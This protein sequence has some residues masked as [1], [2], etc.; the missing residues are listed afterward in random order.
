MG[1]VQWLVV[2]LVAQSGVISAAT[3]PSAQEPARHVRVSLSIRDGKTVFRSGEPIRL[4]ASFTADRPGYQVDT[5]IDK[6]A[7]LED[8]I[9]VTPENGAFRW[10]ELLSTP[11]SYGRDYGN[12]SALSARPV[13]MTMPLNYWFRFDEP[14]DYTVRVRTRRVRVA[15]D[16][17]REMPSPWLMTNAVTFKIVMMTEQE[18]EVEARRLSAL[19]DTLPANDLETQTERCEDLAFLTSDAGTREKV[20]RFLH[21]QGRYDGNWI[22]DLRMGLYI[23]RSTSLVI[24]LLEADMRDPTKPVGHIMELIDLRLWM[25][26]PVLVA[27]AQGDMNALRRRK[28]ARIDALRAEYAKEVIASLAQRTGW[29]RRET[30]AS[31]VSLLRNYDGAPLPV[32]PAPLP[33]VVRRV[34]IDE[35]AEL[36]PMTQGYLVQQHWKDIRD[37][38]LLPALERMLTSPDMW[39]RQQPMA[40]ILDIAPER[41]KPIFIAQMLRP[42]PLNHS[43]FLELRDLTLPEMDGPLLEQITRLAASSNSRDRYDLKI[44]TG[45]LARYGSA[46]ILMDVL[47]LY[48]GRASQLDQETRVDLHA[49]LDRWDEAGAAGRLERAL[50]V[51]TDDSMLLYRLA[52]ARYTKA[53]DAV[54]RSRVDSADPWTVEAAASLISQH[55]P[56]DAR[57][58]LE[59]RL[60]RWMNEWSGRTAELEPDPK[61]TTP[62]ARLQI[63]LIRAI[64]NGK[65]WKVSEAD[66]AR[67][68]QSCLT[69]RCRATFAVR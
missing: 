55:G 60:N 9:E 20:R 43:A 39:V 46:A 50:A 17:L 56:A 28:R 62:E 51:E 67:L 38:K 6:N 22:G 33:T 49:Y 42:R 47:R 24:A 44:K 35:F 13:D 31:L 40:A 29:A 58:V 15:A 63:S 8:Q 66:A 12:S 54:N 26:M 14:G 21:P 4:V 48:E 30:A 34:L 19:L 11:D 16:T 23:S 45:F 61:T 52:N 25:E 68:K 18:E 69:E 65:A 2:L 3:S 27:E 36:E 32:A 37:P 7:R 53:L 5:A 10:R 57:A 41:A 59:A 64:L 1:L